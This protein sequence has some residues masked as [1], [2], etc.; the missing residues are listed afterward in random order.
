MTSRLV[1]TL[2]L[3]SE[4]ID[5]AVLNREVHGLYLAIT[6]LFG[7][8]EQCLAVL[9]YTSVMLKLLKRQ[10]V[11]TVNGTTHSIGVESGVPR[12]IVDRCLGRMRAYLV[13]ARA[14]LDSEFPNFEIVQS[15]RVF[16][17]AA[18]LADGSQHLARVGKALDI[19]PLLLNGVR[20]S[21]RQHLG[22]GTTVQ[23]IS[24]EVH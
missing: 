2:L 9:S 4:G 8:Q 3:D 13:L 12:D 6:A 21:R 15:F 24:T 11:W 18:P 1:L 20:D 23:Q 19:D 5:P 10:V 14:A 7:E 16:D 17:L 22:R